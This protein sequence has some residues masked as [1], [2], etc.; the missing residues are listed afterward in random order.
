[1][2]MS[3]FK[4]AHQVKD[5]ISVH[6]TQGAIDL[7]KK[8]LEG[9]PKQKT[10]LIRA[11]EHYGLKEDII[12]G[13]LTWE[14][15]NVAQNRIQAALLNIVEN[16]IADE[17]NNTKVFI[18]YNREPVCSALAF[19][20]RQK[21]KGE[22][23]Q[24]FMDVEDTPVGADWALTILNEIKT[25]HYF[26]LLLSERGNSSEMVIKEV[27]EAQ[28]RRNETGLP[29]IL[30][31][32]VQFPLEH[33][34]NARLYSLL[35]RIQQIQ[36]EEASDTPKV[37]SKMM[38]VLYGRVNLVSTGAVREEEAQEFV[39]R[40]EIAP[41]PVAPLEVPRGAVRLESKYYI[42]RP[43][44]DVFIS[45][46]ENPGALLRIRGPRQFGKTSLLTRV[47]AHAAEQEYSIIAIDFQEFDEEIMSNLDQ[48]LWEFCSFFAEELDLEDELDKR[49]ARPRA[50]KQ[51]C[52]TFI[53]NDILKNIDQPLLLALDEAD[54]LFRHKEVS[55]EFFL[56][57]RSWHEKSK[58]PGKK[59]WEKFRLV[60][61]YSTEAK[62][63][64]Q[65]LNAS[66]FNVGE[67]AKL[68]PFT[69][70]QVAELLH[71]HGLHWEP[72][73]LQET[74]DL[75]K[76]Q[77]YLVRRALYLLAKEEY[78]YKD[79]MERANKQDGPFSDHLRHHLV[80]LKQFEDASEA[81][82]KI[83]DKGECKDP[84]MAARLEATG[85]VKGSTPDVVPANGLYQAY[86]KGKL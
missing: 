83:V 39:A 1:I 64:I 43:Q 22:G 61:S 62:L 86:F 42:E 44:E 10:I 11:G 51:I 24:L 65:D 29:I 14:E 7:L 84:I 52:T 80:N 27:E 4:I 21:L 72:E 55:T 56:L 15:A 47:I 58:V 33:R 77:P 13:T 8:A 32:R 76:G 26:I 82:K 5:K 50:K 38:D 71:R 30:P 6:D 35:H 9:H 3:I 28:K 57:L 34:L 59:D 69:E 67:E 46:V 53:E 54:R 23:F 60:L 85:L 18:S 36:W 78:T 63:A 48:L 68:T 17:V 74:M 49:W 79:L 40:E 75:L 70:D 37:L 73:K 45:Y 12:T 25:C 20:M 41:S 31:I 16:L 81:M 19:E 2:P 66:P